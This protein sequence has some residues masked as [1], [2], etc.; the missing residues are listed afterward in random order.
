M[1]NLIIFIIGTLLLIY[2]LRGFFRG[3]FKDE[4]YRILS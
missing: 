2:A 3:F 1:M 4:E